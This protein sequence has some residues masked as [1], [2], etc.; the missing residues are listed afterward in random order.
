MTAGAELLRLKIPSDGAS[1][2][3][4][5]SPARQARDTFSA[6]FAVLVDL[7]KGIGLW[8]RSHTHRAREGVPEPLRARRSVL[9]L[10]GLAQRFH[11]FIDGQE[12]CRFQ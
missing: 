9:N 10:I 3:P 1:S 12:D 5:F 2:W 11:C 4:I 7:R 6:V 8:T